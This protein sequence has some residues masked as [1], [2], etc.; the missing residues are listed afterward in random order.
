MFE[1][2]SPTSPPAKAASASSL[3][4]DAV[5]SYEAMQ[6]AVSQPTWYDRLNV[7][8]DKPIPNACLYVLFVGGFAMVALAMGVK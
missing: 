4:A 2:P 1:L 8:L 7:A 6:K 5:P 3:P